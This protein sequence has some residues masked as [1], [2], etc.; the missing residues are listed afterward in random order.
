MGGQAPVQHPM[1]PLFVSG[2]LMELR[3]A[4]EEDRWV[5]KVAEETIAEEGIL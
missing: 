1:M 4:R 3:R 2:A 5:I